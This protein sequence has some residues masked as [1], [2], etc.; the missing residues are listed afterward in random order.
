MFRR[1]SIFTVHEN[2]DAA[3]ICDRVVLVR[4]G[5]SFFAFLFTVLWSLYHRLWLLS[6]VYVV[7][8]AAFY[9][10]IH[11][12]VLQEPVQAILQLGLQCWFGL[13]A[14][15]WQ[16]DALARRGYVETAVVL[17]ENEAFA[18][19]RLYDRTLA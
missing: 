2:P 18:E 16:R 9:Q 7:L 10:A 5:F 17:A 6:L 13:T 14:R 1:E 11:S 19:Q 4:E 12:L 8:A 3:D 15:D